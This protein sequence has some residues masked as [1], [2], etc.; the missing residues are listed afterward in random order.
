MSQFWTFAAAQR[1][2]A[3][4]MKPV[5]DPAGWTEADAEA[6]S[7]SIY[8]FSSQDREEVLEAIETFLSKGLA[9]EDVNRENFPLP[10]VEKVLADVRRELTDGRGIV[11][12]RDFPVEALDRKGAA[13]AYL[14]L[15]CY[16]G[17]RMSQNRYGHILG[18][19][20]DLGGDY[21]DSNTRGY[22]TN[23]EMRFHAD[24][25]DYVGLL[26][27]QKSMRGGES[28][29]ASSVTVY[30]RIL[31]RRPD[32]A[33]VLTQDFYRSRSG[34]YSPGEAPYFKQ[35][36]FSFTDG[37]FSA[38]GAGAAIDK[39]QSLPGVPPYTPAQKEAVELYRQVVEES[40]IEIGFEPGD[41]QLLN[42]FVTLHTRRE[43]VDWPEPERKRHLLRLWLSDPNGRPIPQE[44]RQG[45]SGR[46]VNVA[47]VR[48]HA[49][50]EVD[51]E[52]IV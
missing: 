47:G 38:T 5:A 27:L 16:L 18:H 20:K 7:R 44:Q 8:P 32:L 23:A 46:G 39:A 52:S 26:C 45:R 29:V 36:I 17:D 48:Q 51:A 11:M 10:R 24:A 42:N 2:Y 41:I 19:V 13:I 12:L 15:G 22:M 43:Y 4:A 49:P 21:S 28:C 50:L 40:A 34:E 30:N 37:F 3:E 1:G 25:S 33:E 14:G 35:P 31:E 9:V 6:I